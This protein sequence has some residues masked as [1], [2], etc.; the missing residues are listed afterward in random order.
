VTWWDSSFLPYAVD[1]SGDYLVV[2][3]GYVG[4]PSSQYTPCAYLLSISNSSFYVLDTW[5]YTPPSS[6][7]WQ[8]SLTNWDA[9]VYAEKYQLSV[10]I[11][12]RGDELIYGIQIMNTIVLLNINRTNKRFASSFET[13]SNGKGIG[14]GKSVGWIDKNLIIVLVNTYSLNYVWSLSQVFL[15]NISLVNS[16]VVTSIYPNI[17]QRLSPTF[18]PIIL[19]LVVTENGTVVLLDSQGNYYILLPSPAGSFSDSSSGMVS[20]SSLC[21]AGTFSSESNILPCLL[22]PYGSTTNG[23]I[24]QSSCVPC[25]NDT[26]C[27]LGAAFGDISMSSYLLTSVNQIR[28]YRDCS[29]MT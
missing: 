14:M 13:L 25:A 8:A 9:D 27:S 24:G 12:D 19:S 10:K 29:E 1:I 21:I 3:V 17:Q 16:F 26:F 18:G 23:L 4:D 6:T 15:Y 28:A 11:N 22:C 5:L 20:S 2:V 7:S